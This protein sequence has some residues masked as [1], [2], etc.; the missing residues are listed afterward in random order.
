MCSSC[1]GFTELW[2]VLILGLW[3]LH[4]VWWHNCVVCGD[5]VLRVYAQLTLMGMPR[6][7]V[8]RGYVGLCTVH[9]VRLHYVVC[10]IQ[11]VA[12]LG[13]GLRKIPV[14]HLANTTRRRFSVFFLSSLPN[15]H[16]LLEDFIGRV[17]KRSDRVP[18]IQETMLFCI[19]SAAVQA[20][21]FPLSD[22]GMPGDPTL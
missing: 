5:A 3:G 8:P 13:T 11:Y 12:F 9:F 17:Q 19:R 14:V 7:C 10:R 6:A 4:G 22:I 2:V 20:D 1:G 15:H 16:F 21:G 18:L